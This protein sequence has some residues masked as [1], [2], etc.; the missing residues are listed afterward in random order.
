MLELEDF[1]ELLLDSSLTLRI[2]EE[3]LSFFNELLLSSLICSSFGPM[4]DE[5][6]SPQANIQ[7]IAAIKMGPIA[8]RLK[9]DSV[10]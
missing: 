9:V 4:E 6:S 8:M 2:T 7:T 3:E 5:E 10:L 1:A